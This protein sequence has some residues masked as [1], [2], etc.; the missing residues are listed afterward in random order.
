MAE[1][2][3][4]KAVSVP[5]LVADIMHLLVIFRFSVGQLRLMAIGLRGLEAGPGDQLTM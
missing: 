3:R 4:R 5:G 1:T 2:S